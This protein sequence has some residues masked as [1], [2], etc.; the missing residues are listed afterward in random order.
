M[1][2]F[3]GMADIDR[4]N[5]ATR[6]VDGQVLGSRSQNWLFDAFDWLPPTSYV[7]IKVNRMS[8]FRMKM[9]YLAVMGV[10]AWR[11][12]VIGL[13]R[14]L[15]VSQE[16]L[17]PLRVPEQLTIKATECGAANSYYKRE[18]F[19]PTRDHPCR[20]HAR[21]RSRWPVSLFDFA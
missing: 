8:N 13:V 16:I 1:S 4:Q 18:N 10:A 14:S 9:T 5:A 21:G 15:T 7:R 3:E 2:A 6:H 17:S 20:G 12:F 11:L 19:K